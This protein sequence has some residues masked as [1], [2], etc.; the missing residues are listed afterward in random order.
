MVTFPAPRSSSA[1]TI[2][3]ILEVTDNGSPPLTSYRR[4][5][6][7]IDPGHGKAPPSLNMTD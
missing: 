6:L 2:H 7:T 3:F 5:V 4:I 1:R